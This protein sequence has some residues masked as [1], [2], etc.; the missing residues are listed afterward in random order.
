MKK[1]LSILLFLVFALCITPALAHASDYPDGCTATTAYSSTTGHPCTTPDCAPG[2]LF[3]GL[4]GLPCSSGIVYL[5]GCYSTIGYSVTT[6][7]K[8]DGS[9]VGVQTISQAQN[10]NIS[11]T[12]SDTQTTSVAPLEVV[13]PISVTMTAGDGSQNWDKSYN[14]ATLH[15]VPGNSAG[16]DIV[17]LSYHLTGDSTSGLD[18]FNVAAAGQ[19]SQAYNS[20]NLLD[21]KNPNA[22]Y[23]FDSGYHIEPGVNQDIPITFTFN[24]GNNPASHVQIVFDSIMVHTGLTTTYPLN[25]TSPII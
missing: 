1:S 7:T 14:I 20:D 25:V 4:T 10:T 19:I 18:N 23:L 11:S 2:D 22:G 16:T 15:V 13:P 9:A 21:V 6:G 24:S 12:Q 5:P 8:C 17:Q 3:S